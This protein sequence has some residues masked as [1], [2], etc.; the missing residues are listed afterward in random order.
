MPMSL[1]YPSR[2]VLNATRARQA[3]LGRPVLWVLLFSTALAALALFGAWSASAP[4]LAASE[5][6]AQS[7]AQSARHF[8]TGDAAVQQTAPAPN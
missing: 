4:K 5:P 2:L 6:S 3:R 8:D 1:K 7:Q